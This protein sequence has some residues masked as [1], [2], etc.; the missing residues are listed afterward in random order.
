MATDLMQ[1]GGGLT[2]SK[3]ALATVQPDEV[4]RGKTYYAGDKTLKAGTMAI[5]TATAT[6]LDV[7]S[8][9]TFYAG[10]K[11]LKTGTL[12]ERGQF[13]N[14]GGITGG[15]IVP[16]YAFQ[17]IPEGI[18]RKNGANG[19]PEVRYDKGL[20]L[21]FIL[22]ATPVS[23]RWAALAYNSGRLQ[24]DFSVEANKVYLVVAQASARDGNWG[25]TELV[26]NPNHKKY[27]F[28]QEDYTQDQVYMSTSI[29]VCVFK[30]TEAGSC[31]AAG[32]GLGERTVAFVGI[33]KLVP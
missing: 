3:L 27:V 16:Y 25:Y 10:D 21:D 12:V 23:V 8:G 18:Y 19:A 1:P 14:A 20:T 17:N 5:D 29:K 2:K 24:T 11:T 22:Q 6:T 7:S 31:Y 15:D 30:P 26:I 13:Q 4:F 9:K 33:W 32:T 28:H